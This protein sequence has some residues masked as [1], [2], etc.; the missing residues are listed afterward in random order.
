MQNKFQN[1]VNCIFNTSHKGEGEQHFQKICIAQAY[2]HPK[3][4]QC[5][6]FT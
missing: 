2:P 1:F 5:L 4:P 6:Y 3:D